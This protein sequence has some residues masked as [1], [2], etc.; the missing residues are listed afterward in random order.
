MLALSEN[1]GIEFKRAGD[2]PKSDTYETICAFLNHTGGDILLDV[3][4]KGEVLRNLVGGECL[5]LDLR[6]LRQMNLRPFAGTPA[7]GED[8]N[9]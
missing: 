9:M 3:S 4:D 5:V 2:G 1:V 6:L 7:E 8:R